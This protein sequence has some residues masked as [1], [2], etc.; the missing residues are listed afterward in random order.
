MASSPSPA[1][2]GS[3]Q[4]VPADEL[5]RGL[6]RRQIVSAVLACAIILWAA[7]HPPTR[8]QTYPPGTL[9]WNGVDEIA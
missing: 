9:Y 5:R 7:L 1:S 4:D 6:T 8:I 2:V 3:T